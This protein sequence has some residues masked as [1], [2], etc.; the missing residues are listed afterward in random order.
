ML[1][2]NRNGI[3]MWAMSRAISHERFDVVFFPSVY[4]YVPVIGPAR[5]IVVIHDLIAEDFLQHILSTLLGGVQMWLQVVAARRCANLVMTVSEASRDGIARCFRIPRHQIAVIPEAAYRFFCPL[6]HENML[7]EML[8]RWKLA[9]GRFLLYVGG[10]S[11]H[12]NLQALIDAL[13]ELRRRAG[14]A[15]CKLTLGGDYAGDVFLSD[16]EKLSKR[17]DALQPGDAV[18]ITGYVDEA[19]LAILHSAAAALVL[20]SLAEGFGLP[21]SNT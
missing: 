13:A 14:S 2:E 3:M 4:T 18:V 7:A 21:S 19:S 15:E 1:M 6:P 10:I 12:K 17:A 5:V 8:A 16:C 11:P 20:L 9:D